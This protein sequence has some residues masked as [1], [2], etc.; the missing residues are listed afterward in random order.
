MYKNVYTAQKAKIMDLAAAQL[1]TGG[2]QVSSRGRNLG[3]IGWQV[4][5]E[6]MNRAASQCWGAYK[7]E[8][9]RI[10]GLSCKKGPMTSEEVRTL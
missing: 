4:I 5:G 6:A 2:N 10:N 8:L 7:G 9:R 1:A 3:S